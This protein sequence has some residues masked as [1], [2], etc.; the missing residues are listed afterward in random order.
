M[1]APK[2][3]D[4]IR[5]VLGPQYAKSKRIQRRIV[6]KVT[7]VTTTTVTIRGRG[8]LM[9]GGEGGICWMCGQALTNPSSVQIGVGPECAKAIG[10]TW[11]GSIRD[12]QLSADELRQA[13]ADMHTTVTLPLLGVAWGPVDGPAPILAMDRPR[14]PDTRGLDK[15]PPIGAAPTNLV[16]LDVTL[17]D[18]YRFFPYQETGV[19]MWLTAGDLLL[20]DDMGLGKTAQVIGGILQ[21]R[22]L[23]R[24]DPHFKGMKRIPSVIVCPKSLRG[25]WRIELR[26]FA[27]DLHVQVLEGRDAKLLKNQDI[28]ITHY[29][30]LASRKIGDRPV[31]SKAGAALAKLKM[32]ALVGDESHR[33]KTASA[34]RTL[35]MAELAKSAR[36]RALLSGTAILARPR[37][38]IPQLEILDQMEKLFGSTSAYRLRFCNLTLRRFGKRRVWDDSGRSNLTELNQRLAPIMLRRRKEDVLKDLPPKTYAR[39]TVELSNREA[40]ARFEESIADADPSQRA[41][42]TSKL[43]ALMAEG[44]IEPATDWVASFLDST[45]DEKLVVFAYH[46]NVQQALVAAFPTAA[47]IFASA[48]MQRLKLDVEEEKRRFQEDPACRLIVCSLLAAGFGH[49]LTAASN[50]LN[51]ELDYTPGNMAQAGDRIH[52]PGQVWP[53][54]IWTLVAEDS[55]DE[56]L[57]EILVEKRQV[58]GVVLDGEEQV[59]DEQS[60]TKAAVADILRRVRERKRRAA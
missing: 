43:R 50:L 38:L 4:L 26:R 27:P 7:A 36:Y 14:P 52:R 24:N 28:Y 23:V 9:A 25:N 44:K 16:P 47:R 33:I 6:G 15:M 48:D 41:A 10:I 56:R 3:G 54:T 51:V 8:E 53:C 18:P 35:A 57:T 55:V 1:S 49:T 13:K 39:V 40:Y 29:E 45:D 19:R 17:P 21:A 11:L 12:R 59:I 2:I 60:V 42:M 34:I 58:T 5:I 22:Y 46:R 30:N 31:L 37:E 32:L 20:A